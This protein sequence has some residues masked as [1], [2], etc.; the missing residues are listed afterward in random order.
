MSSVPPIRGLGPR[1][2]IQPGNQATICVPNNPLFVD[3][4][5]CLQEVAVSKTAS[6]FP[7]VWVPRIY[8]G[9]RISLSVQ[10]RPSAA[11]G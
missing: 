1:V 6:V 10:G 2:Q 3:L 7:I 11:Q 5:P 4:G 9:V 8:T